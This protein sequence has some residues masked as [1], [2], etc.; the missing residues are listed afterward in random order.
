MLNC[1]CSPPGG[2]NFRR[3]R[4]P[5]LLALSRAPA[6]GRFHETPLRRCTPLAGSS[7]TYNIVTL[8]RTIVVFAFFRVEFNTGFAGQRKNPIKTLGV[9]LVKIIYSII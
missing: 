8:S 7:R 4:R 2:R 6:G 3:G 9:L 5:V 1:Y